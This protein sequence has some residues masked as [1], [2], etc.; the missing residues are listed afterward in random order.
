M[1]RLDGGEW[2]LR[3]DMHDPWL[4]DWSDDDL[5]FADHL[6][7]P[8][9]QNR[10]QAS[11]AAAALKLQDYLDCCDRGGAFDGEILRKKCDEARVLWRV[12]WDRRPVLVAHERVR[13]EVIALECLD[14]MPDAGLVGPD[15]VLGPSRPLGPTGMADLTGL[16]GMAQWAVNGPEQSPA[17]RWTRSQHAPDAKGRRNVRAIWQAP[18]GVW[19]VSVREEGVVLHDLVGLDER[20]VP[21]GVVAYRSDRPLSDGDG[22]LGR[23]VPCESGWYLYAGIRLKKVPP[24]DY[25]R[26]C[27]RLGLARARLRT[28]R[29]SVEDVLRR[30]GSW[31][32]R[33]ILAYEPN[34]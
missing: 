19:R 12:S 15:A 30:F 11:Y 29:S 6:K 28:R 17:E 31:W 9:V 23:V 2:P 24:P 34:D 21:Q 4:R 27:L 16:F 26:A 22:V 7:C 13:E 3:T 20:R 8:L 33:R 1:K 32:A 10:D 5:G 18:L 14:G 25:I